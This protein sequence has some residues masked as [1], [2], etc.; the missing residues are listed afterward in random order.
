MPIYEYR[1]AV[2]GRKVAIWWRSIAQMDRSHLKCS[3]CGGDQLRRLVSKVAQ[4]RSE[5]SHLESLADSGLGG[6]DESDPRSLGR[7]MRRMSSE[8]GEDMGEEFNEM[9]GRLEAG[10][11]PE[12]IEKSMPG[13]GDDGGIESGDAYDM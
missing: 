7:W 1:C 13:M 11:D 5:D 3:R 8:V 4:L 12:E 10:E 6:L 9:V 2:C